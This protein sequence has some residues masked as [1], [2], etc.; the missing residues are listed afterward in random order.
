MQQGLWVMGEPQAVT[1]PLPPIWDTLY[2]CKSY[3]GLPS[4]TPC[5]D[6]S[7]HPIRWLGCSRPGVLSTRKVLVRAEMEWLGA[8]SNTCLV[9]FSGK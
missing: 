7:S 6:P 9:D 8:E 2:L 3:V 5:W 1:D 4:S